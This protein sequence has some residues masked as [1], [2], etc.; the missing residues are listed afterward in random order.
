[1]RPEMFRQLINPS[2]QQRNLYVSA[3]RVLRVQLKRNRFLCLCH[4]SSFVLFREPRIIKQQ[5]GKSRR[6]SGN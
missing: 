3:P 6:F 1:M 5:R 4:K 2:S